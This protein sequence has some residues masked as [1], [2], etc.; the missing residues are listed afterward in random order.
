MT[1]CTHA[2][3]ALI[4]LLGARDYITGQPFDVC[5]CGGCGLALTAP[6]PGDLGPYYPA[7]YYRPNGARRF[8]APVEWLQRRLCASRARVVERLVG[9]PGSV[10]DIGCGPGLFLDAFRRRGWEAH[11]TELS[12]R[13]AEHAR[14]LGLPVQVGP[15]ESWPWSDA[16]FDAVV[17]WHALEH[18]PHPELALAAAHRLLRPGGVLLVGVPNFGSPEARDAREGWFHLD[19]PRH[20]HHFT[21][22]A[23][24][25]ALA[26]AGFLPRRR[27]FFAPEFDLFS[28]VQSLENRLGLRHNLLYNLL[29][30]RNARVLEEKAGA[31]QVLTSVLLAAPLGLLAL[32]VTLL[33]SLLH[34]GSSMSVLAVR[35]AGV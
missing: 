16:S 31:A 18:W 24:A 33:L 8:P 5:R 1:A 19:V 2:D 14:T 34:R 17:M 15:L 26:S 7:S 32:P 22:E 21:P 30:R 6:P 29:R 11:G 4:P 3:A 12:D 10:L 13:S 35:K 25:D 27:S 9:G 20:L 28:A 23:L